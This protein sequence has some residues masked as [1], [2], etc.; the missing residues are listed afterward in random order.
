M[1][2]NSP[3]SRM[4]QPTAVRPP[5]L[6]PQPVRPM[7]PQ[8]FSQGPRP[9]ISKWPNADAWSGTPLAVKTP[10]KI[11]PRYRLP[12]SLNDTSKTVSPPTLGVPPMYSGPVH[13]PRNARVLPNIGFSD[14]ERAGVNNYNPNRSDAQTQ[15]DNS[16]GIP[17]YDT[18]SELPPPEISIKKAG[19]PEGSVK[20]WPD[21]DVS[22]DYQ[23]IIRSNGKIPLLNEYDSV[24]T[25]GHRYQVNEPLR[26]LKELESSWKAWLPYSLLFGSKMEP[27][28]KPKP[29]RRRDSY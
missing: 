9:L 29:P 5:M 23:N 15:Y 19:V 1:N 10:D 27:L 11:R 6:G 18:M 25:P 8:S 22:E 24:T 28:P 26:K 7:N 16:L 20:N 13:P 2:Y 4:L 21:R 12:N 14:S 17:M 3:E